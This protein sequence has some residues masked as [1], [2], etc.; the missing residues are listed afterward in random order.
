MIERYTLPEIGAIWSD[1]SR[2]SIWLEIERHACAAQARLGIIPKPALR[3]IERKAG[4]DVA[5]IQAIEAE[6][7]HDVIAFLTSVAEHVGEASRYIHYGLTSSDVLDTALSVQIQKAGRL[8]LD[9]LGRLLDDAGE[10]AWRH[11]DTPTMGRTHGVYAEPLALG[12][13]FA[14]WYT[15]L[16]RDRERLAAALERCRVGKL[17]GAVG[18]FAH[19]DPSVEAYVCRRM[20][21]KPAPVSNQIVQRDRH[22]ELLSAMAICGATIERIALEVRHLQRSEVREMLEGFGARQ[23]GSS[24]MP[25][26][27]NPILCERLCGM[28]RLLR[29]YAQTGFENIA[30][31]HERDIS[32]SSVERVTFPDA[33]A[34]LYYMLVKTRGLLARLEIDAARMLE[35]V[36]AAGGV[37]FSQRV[38]LALVK[39]GM[40]REDAYRLVQKHALKAWN[41]NG[42]FRALAGADPQV[43]ALLQRAELEAC[44]D[45]APYMARSGIILE[46]SVRRKAPRKA[47]GRKRAK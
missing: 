19:V 9:E 17:S 5:R 35:H 11:V 41:E 13:K 29:S 7:N 22:A 31:W 28:A 42:S 18:N 3:E 21:L 33:T 4:F 23:K 45:L 34:I 26:K 47:A 1:E 38:L 20:G 16:E 36:Q 39:A 32:H 15:Q 2:F 6:V 25:H 24:A 30:L 40:S 12:Q 46:R 44:F 10:L 14:I 43:R 8:M 27:R 37:V